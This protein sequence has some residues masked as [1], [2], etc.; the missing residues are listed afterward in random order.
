MNL[1][2]QALTAFKAARSVLPK[3]TVQLPE[4]GGITV[5]GTSYTLDSEY[6]LELSG[7]VDDVEGGVRLVCDELGPRQPEQGDEIMVRDRN[8]DMQTYNITR[9][10]NDDFDGTEEGP[11][12]MLIIYGTEQS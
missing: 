2:T 5:T 9:I 7:V 3:K 11:A 8:Q 12:T 1:R 4:C 10:R 6:E